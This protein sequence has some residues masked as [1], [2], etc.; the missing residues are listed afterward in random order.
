MHGESERRV[1]VVG[2]GI[3]YA[4]GDLASSVDRSGGLSSR[5][6]Q[7]LLSRTLYDAVSDK[8]A[9]SH[10]GHILVLPP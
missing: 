9:V 3:L 7:H 2:W 8:T 6:G 4:D 5:L 10:V 1:L